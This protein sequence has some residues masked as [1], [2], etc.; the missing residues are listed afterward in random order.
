MAEDNETK[1]EL[2]DIKALLQR[3]QR[4]SDVQW[5]YTIGFAG[6]IGSLALLSANAASWAVLLVF[7]AGFGLMI[8]APYIK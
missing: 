8:A 2:A 5:V 4:K 7:F 1:R 3:A 6:V